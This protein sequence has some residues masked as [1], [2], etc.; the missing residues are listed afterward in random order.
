MR[1]ERNREWERIKTLALGLGL[2]GVEVTTTWG[3]PALKA[4][5]KLE[6]PISEIAGT[7]DRGAPSR[8]GRS[9]V[10]HVAYAT[11]KVR[12][13]PVGRGPRPVVSKTRLRH[14]GRSRMA[15]GGV[16]ALVRSPSYAHRA[17]PGL[18]PS[19]LVMRASHF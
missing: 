13:E 7:P 8:S 12:D 2:P 16:G 14:D 18:R 15:C 5:G 9:A 19:L 10:Q 3:E 6:Y 11:C 17:P 4:F 1:P